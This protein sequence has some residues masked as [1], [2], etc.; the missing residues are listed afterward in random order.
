MEKH[1]IGEIGEFLSFVATAFISLAVLSVVLSKS[2]AT[3]GVIN[4]LTQAYAT[5]LRIVLAPASATNA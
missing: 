1:P 5:I 3:V 4:A 2:S